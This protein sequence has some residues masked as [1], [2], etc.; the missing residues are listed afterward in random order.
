MVFRDLGCNV[1]KPYE[2]LKIKL[3]PPELVPQALQTDAELDRF[4]AEELKVTNVL[5]F[6]SQATAERLR[7]PPAITTMIDELTL[8]A[9]GTPL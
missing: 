1:Q 5:L 6:C 4:L 2:A 9:A 7:L 3:P 8:T